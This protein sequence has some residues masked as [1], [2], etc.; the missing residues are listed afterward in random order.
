MIRTR[1]LK[2]SF[3]LSFLLTL[4]T[5]PAISKPFPVTSGLLRLTSVVLPYCKIFGRL[6]VLGGFI[7][8]HLFFR[9]I[10]QIMYLH[11]YAFYIAAFAVKQNNLKF[12]FFLKR[13]C[14]LKRI[15]NLNGKYILNVKFNLKKP[16][17]K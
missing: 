16:I 1:I 8:G 2:A 14:I 12:S 4:F 7:F 11:K 15:R 3:G 5:I 9:N 10:L 13:L 6:K 17:T